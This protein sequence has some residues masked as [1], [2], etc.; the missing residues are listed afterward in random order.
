MPKP[1]SL[2]WKIVVVLL[3]APLVDG[4]AFRNMRDS[5]S[6]QPSW[7]LFRLAAFLM[8]AGLVIWLA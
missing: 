3:F 2:F 6:N 8:W 4:Y 1:M 7:P 5:L